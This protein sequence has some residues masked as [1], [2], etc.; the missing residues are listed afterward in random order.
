MVRLS[1]ARKRSQGVK[2]PPVENLQQLN[3]NAAGIDVGAAEIWVAV[4]AE[5]ATPSVRVFETFTADLQCAAAWLIECG[6]TTVAMESTGIYWIPLYEILEARGVEVQL[7]HATQTKHVTG[8]KSDLVDCQW[9]QQLHTY[10]LLRPSFR[11]TAEICA[12][13][14]L[15]RHRETLLQGRAVQIQHMQKALHLMNL[16][17]TNV[18][19][20]ITG[21]TGLQIIRAIVAGERDPQV[22]AHYRHGC[23]A[24]SEREIAKSLEGHYQPEHLFVLQQALELYEVYSQKLAACD[25]QIE[26][27]C[28]TF[29]PQ[30]DVQQHPLPPPQRERRSKNSPAFDLRTHLYQMAGVDLTAIPGI[31]VLTAQTLLAEIGLDMSRWP[32]V[33]QFS[34]WLRLA[35]QHEVSGGKLLR[36]R[37]KP[38]QNRA[39]AALRLAAQSVSRSD[40]ALGA[41][42][43]RLRSKHGAPKAIT[44]TAHKL[45]RIVYS[46]LKERTPYHEMGA[47]AYE[48][49][50]QQRVLNNLKRKAKKL[51]MELVPLPTDRLASSATGSVS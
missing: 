30:V 6:V 11:P 1:Q 8:R 33:K 26:A 27:Y 16:Q 15:V 41:F 50:Y 2:P 28:A 44:A 31:D 9:I 14:S 48:H 23:C 19:T 40:S 36:Q 37:T 46:L 25:E 39:A 17:L 4:P 13:R 45:A 42:Y 3:L 43:R 32:T 29:V 12:L 22:L 5:R 38:T 10:G 24:K 51:G 21:Q 7:V 35:P 34:A 20:D 18:L 49:Q 47:D